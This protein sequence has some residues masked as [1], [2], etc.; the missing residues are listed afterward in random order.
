MIPKSMRKRSQ[1]DENAIPKEK[2]TQRA[3]KHEKLNLVR[4]RC[5]KLVHT[6]GRFKH[7]TLQTLSG[8]IFCM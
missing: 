7:K 6:Q 5:Q 4:K 3:N 8:V 2:P 1:F